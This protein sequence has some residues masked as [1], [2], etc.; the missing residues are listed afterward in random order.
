M[1][2]HNL[3]NDH[4]AILHKFVVGNLQVE[5]CWAFSNTSRRIVM[6]TVTWAIIASE[7]SG[8]GDWYTSKMG[9]NSQNYE[10]FLIF[11]PF[12]I[13]LW[14]SK[15]SNVDR[16]FYGDFFCRPEKRGKC[17]FNAFYK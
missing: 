7:F 15:S 9:A 5:G 3:T 13:M 16:L 11:A 8:I 4:G 1:F 14:M 2:F 6:G 12:A 10:P 17:T